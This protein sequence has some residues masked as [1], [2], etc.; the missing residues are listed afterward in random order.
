MRSGSV[1]TACTIPV[2][3]QHRG[4]AV[5]AHEQ[6][7]AAGPVPF[8]CGNANR[9][10]DRAIA[11]LSEC[12]GAAGLGAEAGAARDGVY[13]NRHTGRPAAGHL[14]GHRGDQGA[15]R[16]ESS[17]HS[18]PMDGPKDTTDRSCL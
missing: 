12:Q 3:G 1:A 4:A 17:A 14:E 18:V 10:D 9:L 8:G 11:R 5:P 2:S 15:S 7:V 13:D 6:V 16:S